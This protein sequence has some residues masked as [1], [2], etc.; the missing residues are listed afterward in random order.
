MN[1][2]GKRLST[3]LTD[4]SIDLIAKASKA[5]GDVSEVLR[6]AAKDTYEFVHSGPS[7]GTTCSSIS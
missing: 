6:A 2:F 7:G 4:R 3:P 1:R 5:G